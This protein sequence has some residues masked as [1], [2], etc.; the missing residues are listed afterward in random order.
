MYQKQRHSVLE[1]HSD[2]V[3]VPFPRPATNIPH[4]SISIHHCARI[5]S[6][7]E[8][9]SEAFQPIGPNACSL[10]IRKLIILY[11]KLAVVDIH[12]IEM[13]Q[14]GLLLVRSDALA[15]QSS[16]WVLDP[17]HSGLEIVDNLESFPHQ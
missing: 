8:P 7:A 16:G 5:S 14:Q 10:T 9:W 4:V 17:K 3:T 13:I 2:L 11:R 15:E 12:K 6:G 1:I